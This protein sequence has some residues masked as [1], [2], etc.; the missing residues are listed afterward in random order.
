MNCTDR[1]GKMYLMCRSCNDANKIIAFLGRSTWERGL[2][3]RGF[4]V[5]QVLPQEGLSPPCERPQVICTLIPLCYIQV[6]ASLLFLWLVV[7]GTEPPHNWTASQ[8][9]T[10][11][12]ITHA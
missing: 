5:L 11:P 7:C 2:G 3:R 9:G 6:S 1:K 8:W 10:S 4:W 12:H